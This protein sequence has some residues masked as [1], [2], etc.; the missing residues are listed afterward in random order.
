M[1]CDVRL[2]VASCN[3]RSKV[4]MCACKPVLIKTCDMQEWGI[5]RSAKCNRNFARCFIIKD[6]NLISYLNDDFSEDSFYL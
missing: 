1:T 4:A 2:Q 5:F 6:T 3:V